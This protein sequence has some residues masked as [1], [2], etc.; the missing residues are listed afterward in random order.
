MTNGSVPPLSVQLSQTLRGHTSDVNAVLFSPTSSHLLASCSSDKTIRLWNLNNQSSTTLTRHTY[1]VHWLCFSPILSEENQNDSAAKYM[2]SV[3]TDGT[4]LLWDLSTVSVLKEYKHDSESP[5]RVCQFSADGTLLATG[6]F[7][8]SVEQFDFAFHLAGDDELINLWDITTAS[9]RPVKT[10]TGHSASIVALRFFSNLLISGSFYG[11]LKLWSIDS[12]FTGHLYIEREAHDLGVTCID[13]HSPV[14]TE[15]HHHHHPPYLIASGGN[16]NFVKIWHCSSSSKHHLTLIKTLKKHTC[17]VMC[18]AF[19]IEHYLASGSGDKT[20]VIWN[21]D[22]GHLVHQFNAHTRYVTCCSFS[23]DGQYL[24]S[25][26]ND[27]MVNIWKINYL[28]NET[29]KDDDEQKDKVID[30]EEYELISIE[31]WPTE[32]VKQWLEQF[33]IRTKLNLTGNDLLAK[34][35]H[36]ILEIFGRND[37]LLTELSSLKHKHFI[38]QFA[39][40]KTN[41]KS[42]PNEYLCPITHE[43]MTD[44]VCVSDGY[45][46][47]RKA[48]EEWLTKKQSS[49]ILNLSIQGTQL[50]PNKVLKMLIDQYMQQS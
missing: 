38:K 41:E 46:Y 27:R 2:A 23:L 7:L 14:S 20:V 42:I 50:Y 26:S 49:P 34:S 8:C 37:Q 21:Y 39:S 43:I 22:T 36:E 33:Q 44:P 9:S 6:Q 31:Q 18:V 28:E 24:V 1:Q 40:K 32:M 11:D 3:S 47:E 13:V 19:G 4:C 12:S 10:L 48:I 30:K 25:G 45:T 5:I 29:K 35:D 15:S 17:A 16:D